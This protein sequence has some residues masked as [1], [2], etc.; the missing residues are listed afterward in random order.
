MYFTNIRPKQR[1]LS[2]PG[3]ASEQGDKKVSLPQLSSVQLVKFSQVLIFFR[4]LSFYKMAEE[5]EVTGIDRRQRYESL[6]P[7]LRALAE[8]EIDTIANLANIMSGLK[9]GMGF[10]WVGIYFVYDDLDELVL[11]PF[12]GPVACT[13]IKKGKGVCGTCWEKAE[14][15]IVP[16]VDQFPGHI[17]CSTNSRSEIAVPVLK[18]G[19]VAAVLDVDSDKLNDLT[20]VD[21][22]HLEKVAELISSLIN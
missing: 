12:Q 4:T 21:K 6:L 18:N 20:E 8:G 2:R 19:E 17:A 22:E 13:R 15:V 16:D 9:Y 1:P 7:Q 14:T 10:F 5:F 3:I 11:G